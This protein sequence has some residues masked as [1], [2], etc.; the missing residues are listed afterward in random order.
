[1]ID[2]DRALRLDGRVALITGATR[3]IGRAI[4]EAYAAAGAGIC[5][6]ARKPAE[7][8]ETE[9][10]LRALGAP[11]V[12]I[13]G[14]AGDPEVITTAVDR[15]V[16]ELGRLDVLVNN[17]ATNPTFGPIIETE[18]RAVRKVLEVNVEGPLLLAQAAWRA[19]MAEHGG[20]I[21]NVVSTGGIRPAP[22]IGVYNASKAALLH[23]TKQLALELAP[24]VRV[25][26]LAP[27]LVRTKFARALWGVDEAAVASRHPMKR[28]GAP[29]DI[30]AA[31]LLLASDASSFMTG[32]V[33][34]L[35]GGMLLA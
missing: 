18:P 29:D 25:N 21:V 11:V 20:S 31:A 27:G 1:M 33:I 2:P 34:V 14:S 23:M 9:T 7:L 15:C 13:A 4:A 28:I 32:E 35:D 10:A 6:L 5:V 17:A 12:T 16:T 3:G 8:E 24:G 30:A 19:W 26:A 22:F